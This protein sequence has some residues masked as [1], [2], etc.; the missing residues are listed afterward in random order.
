[1]THILLSAFT[2]L[3]DASLTDDE[4]ERGMLSMNIA[5]TATTR[6]LLNSLAPRFVNDRMLKPHLFNLLFH[7]ATLQFSSSFTIAHSERRGQRGELERHQIIQRLPDACPMTSTLDMS[8]LACGIGREYWAAIGRL[9]RLAVLKLNARHAQISPLGI[10]TLLAGCAYLQVLD[11]GLSMIVTDETLFEI[12]KFTRLRVLALTNLEYVTD[13][14]LR[15]LLQIKTL[16]EL[17][18]KTLTPSTVCALLTTLTSL[19]SSSSCVATGAAAAAPGGSERG[20]N[21]SAG[22][23]LP[24]L[25]KLKLEHHDYPLDMMIPAVEAMRAARPAVVL[26]ITPHYTALYVF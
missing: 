12:Q 1:M 2:F 3:P 6:G 23:P 21:S 19:S 7:A 20:D 16:S 22:S 13:I 9:P 14:G 5:V 18:L 4:R 8:M 24:R 17:T 11:G 26:A 25:S 10:A 15:S